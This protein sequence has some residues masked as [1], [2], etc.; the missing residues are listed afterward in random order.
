MIF[1]LFLF[2]ETKI[3]RRCFFSVKYLPYYYTYLIKRVKNIFKLLQFGD[4]YA[5]VLVTLKAVSNRVV[6]MY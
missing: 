1:V 6:I 3:V 4:F 2:L 5:I